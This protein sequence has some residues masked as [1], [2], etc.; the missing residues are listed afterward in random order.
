MTLGVVIPICSRAEGIRLTLESLRRQSYSDFVV[1]IA[2]DGSTD[3]SR[4]VVEKTSRDFTRPDAVR[5]VSGGPNRGV[6][7]GRARNIGAANLPAECEYMVMLDSD[8]ILPADT[9]ARFVDACGRHP[10]AVVIGMTEWLPPMDSARQYQA[11]REGRVSDLRAAVPRDKPQR[12]QGT[13][14]GPELREWLWPGLFH[15]DPSR[16]VPLRPEWAYSNN[17]CYPL[18]V[19][20]QAGGFDERMCGYGYQDIE[21]GT[22]VSRLG[23]NCLLAAE[24][25]ALHVWHPKTA[26]DT[27]LAEVQRNLDYLFRQHG[28]NEI[29]A[30]DVD[31]SYWRHYHAARGGQLA[32]RDTGTWAINELQTHRLLLPSDQWVKRLGF[33][34]PSNV[35]ATK[36]AAFEAMTDAGVATD[37]L[38]DDSEWAC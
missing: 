4:A 15:S 12:I 18:D 7:T 25:W 2:D 5:W 27:R 20:W 11:I 6:R 36:D 31:W 13:F 16:L 3:D 22:R 29:F 17:V 23:Q 8:V 24:I 9:L 37:V 21:F 30:G 26:S 32:I 38:E 10:R 28:F 33:Q 34:I 35:P 19:F 1:L 14:V